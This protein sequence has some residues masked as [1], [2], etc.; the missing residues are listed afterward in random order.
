MVIRAIRVA[1]RAGLLSIWTGIM[2]VV[3]IAAMGSGPI[4]RP[5]QFQRRKKLC[6]IWA[7]G[8]AR[9]IGMRVVVQG[10]PPPAPFYLVSNH[11]S[12]LD[13]YLIMSILGCLFVVKG[14]AAYWPVFGYI[15]RR[16]NLIFIDRQKRTDT[17]RVNELIEKT[18]NQGDSITVFAES[19]TSRGLEIRPFKSALLEAAVD[20]NFPV[21]YATIHYEANP[22]SPPASEWVCW[23]RMES[24]GK[25]TIRMM[26]YSG[27]TATVTFG[28]EPVRAND[29]KELAQKLWEAAMTQFKPVA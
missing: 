24:F 8:L 25:H 28:A 27:F 2:L 3:F 7:R 21:H 6:I 20:L 17:V 26:G 13:A 15:A 18:L 10:T 5:K 23:W 16:V 4:E 14:E 9:I 22:G 12:H 29:R 19:T 11:L 1:I